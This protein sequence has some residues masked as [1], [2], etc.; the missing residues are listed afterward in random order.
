MI[1]RYAA[2]RGRGTTVRK[3]T[4][5]AKDE[6]SSGSASNGGSQRDVGR[7]EQGWN[8]ASR[9]TQLPSSPYPQ[10][11]PPKGI[12]LSWQE[13]KGGLQSHRQEGWILGHT[14]GMTG[15]AP[16]R[17]STPPAL[18]AL[19]LRSLHP[20]GYH[21]FVDSWCSAE[22]A[23]RQQQHWQREEDSLGCVGRTFFFS[24]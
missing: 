8:A 3:T 2:T 14:N 9:T 19:D 11:P 24:M 15:G 22:G 16:P 23:A 5:G 21:H 17:L 10:Q 18:P 4:R 7:R 12:L 20:A 6:G 13:A 1:S